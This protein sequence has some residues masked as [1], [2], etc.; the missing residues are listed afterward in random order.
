MVAKMTAAAGAA[1][2]LVSA[3]SGRRWWLPIVAA[4][5]VTASEA[6]KDSNVP[7]FDAPTSVPNTPDGIQNAVSGLFAFSRNDI[8]GYVQYMGGFA[9]DAVQ[10]SNGDPQILTFYTGLTPIPAASDGVWDNEYRDVG[11]ALTVIATVPNTSPAYSTAQA[12]AIVGI[13]Q[14]LEAIN[15]MLVAETRDTLGIPIY[16]SGASPGPVYCNKDVWARIVALLDTANASLDAA[17]PIPLPIRVPAGFAAVGATAGPSTTAGSFASLNRALAGKAGVELAYAIAR[18]SPATHPTPT[19]PGSPDVNALTRADSAI[20]ASALFNPGALAPASQGNFT[21]PNGVYWDFS[22]QSG[23]L[24]NP[25]NQ[26]I[27]FYTVLKTYVADVD[28]LNDLRWKAKFQANPYQIELPTYNYLASG[29]LFDFYATTNAP[30]PI[31]RNET[32]VLWRAQAQ[33]G[34]GNLAN[35]LTYINDVRTSVG[36]LAPVAGNDYVTVRNLLLKEQ[37]PSLVFEGSGD[38]T[39]ALRM[40]NL[41]AVADTT[42][43]AKDLH[44]TVLPVEE[45]EIEGRNGSYNL[46]CQ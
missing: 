13:A 6:C 34:L 18:N 45:Q 42:W 14:T 5:A 22:S 30:I 41:E 26:Q 4:V 31:I 23:D 15:L 29:D 3:R 25:I 35:A 27:G 39:I 40:Y 43:G 12:A 28:T 10:M 32:L 44:T 33:L 46:T 9:R 21:D 19:T 38:R 20:A 8:G 7:Y 11:E 1:R 16:P 24:V 37:R 2:A 17:G 36:G